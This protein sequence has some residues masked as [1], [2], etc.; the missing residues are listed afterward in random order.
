MT[1]LVDRILEA[2]AW[3]ATNP[4]GPASRDEYRRREAVVIARWI[5]SPP[6]Q[7]GVLWPG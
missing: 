4:Q 2:L 6:S 3:L 7:Q 1:E 5:E